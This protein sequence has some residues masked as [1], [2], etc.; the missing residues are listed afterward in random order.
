MQGADIHGRKI[1]VEI[2]KRNRPREPTP[3]IKCCMKEG[4]LVRRGHH[5]LE[6]DTIESLTRDHVLVHRVGHTG[7]T[8]IADIIMKKEGIDGIDLDLDLDHTEGTGTATPDRLADDMYTSPTQLNINNQL[9]TY[10]ATDNLPE[11]S[12]TTMF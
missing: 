11:C 8:V 2:S 10:S 9:P 1:T 5:L 6:G 7:G 3:G 4:I 12:R